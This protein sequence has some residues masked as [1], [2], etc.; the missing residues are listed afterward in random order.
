MARFITLY[1]IFTCSRCSPINFYCFSWVNIS[2]KFNCIIVNIILFFPY[3]FITKCTDLPACTSIFNGLYINSFISIVTVC[4]PDVA[5]CVVVDVEGVDAFV[6]QSAVATRI[7]F[8]INAISSH[9]FNF[10]RLQ[11]VDT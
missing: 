8:D 2:I 11:M 3:V 10:V 4:L 7:V 1:F 9:F 6:E 5:D